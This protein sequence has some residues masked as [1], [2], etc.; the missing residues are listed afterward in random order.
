MSVNGFSTPK[1][2]WFIMG[3]TISEMIY[4]VQFIEY[5]CVIIFQINVGCRFIREDI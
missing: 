3:Y 5:I 1:T 4:K 2:N